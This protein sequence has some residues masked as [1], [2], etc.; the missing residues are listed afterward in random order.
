MAIPSAMGIGNFFM[1]I[2]NEILLYILL[3]LFLDRT[4][5]FFV[6]VNFYIHISIYIHFL[7]IFIY[8]SPFFEIYAITVYPFYIILECNYSIFI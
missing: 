8:I 5:G 1:V 2:P 6:Y 4:F 3:F 7:Y